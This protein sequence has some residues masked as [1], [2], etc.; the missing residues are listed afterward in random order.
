MLVGRCEFGANLGRRK[1]SV[2]RRNFCTFT[3]WKFTCAIARFIPNHVCECV[4]KNG[5]ISSELMHSSAVCTVHR[6]TVWSVYKY[7]AFAW[8]HEANEVYVYFEWQHR[9]TANHLPCLKRLCLYNVVVAGCRPI[10]STHWALSLLL[11]LLLFRSRIWLPV[12]NVWRL[13]F[14]I[15]L[16]HWLA[17]VFGIHIQPNH[18]RPT[19]T[20]IVLFVCLLL[21]SSLFT[22]L[23][24]QI[25]FEFLFF[26]ICCPFRVRLLW[27]FVC[28]FECVLVCVCARVCLSMLLVWFSFASGLRRTD[29]RL[30]CVKQS[31][32][33]NQAT[34]T[35][36]R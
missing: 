31:S 10:V 8:S 19:Y 13:D 1:D 35:E 16:F 12:Q 14:G 15:F 20:D 34:P 7:Y 29:K 2:H 32:E 3:Q 28:L 6:R 9:Q 21:A 24:S 22:F 33:Q 5:L 30:L 36:I 23:N 17:Y 4:W 25:D 26:F 18:N 11:L 27:L